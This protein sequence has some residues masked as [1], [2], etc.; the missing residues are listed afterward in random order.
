[1]VGGDPF[2]KYSPGR[3]YNVW[4]GIALMVTFIFFLFSHVLRSPHKDQLSNSSQL[5]ATDVSDA[6]TK[7]LVCYRH[8]HC[9]KATYDTP[10]WLTDDQ[11][12][13]LNCLGLIAET[14]VVEQGVFTGLSTL[15]IASGLASAGRGVDLLSHDIYP[16]S[17]CNDQPYCWNCD[18]LNCN[19]E[20]RG[21]ALVDYPVSRHDFDAGW[22][23]YMETFGSL[24]KWVMSRLE[25]Y[26]LLDH[27][28]VVTS[29]RVVPGRYRYFFIDT[30]H[31]CS[32]IALNAANIRERATKDAVLLFHDILTE[33]TEQCLLSVFGREKVLLSAGLAVI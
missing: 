8:R 22:R 4:P 19:L 28:Y 15:H 31:S 30:S 23:P 10:G 9:Q 20:I 17:A 24:E 25:K 32:E 26:N 18:D 6:H 21:Q 13:L 2:A 1:M 27:V 29:Q 33:E 14:T 5:Q 12:C 16:T 3:L 11:K 7:L